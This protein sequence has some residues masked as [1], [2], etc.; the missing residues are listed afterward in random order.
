M[1]KTHLQP[2]NWVT[3][4]PKNGPIKPAKVNP[5]AVAPSHFPLSLGLHK[6]AIIIQTTPSTPPRPNPCIDLKNISKNIELL[7]PHNIVEIKNINNAGI[8]I[9]FGP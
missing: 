5:A 4:A 3:Y 9:F 7:I 1:K 2:S 8:M 6:S